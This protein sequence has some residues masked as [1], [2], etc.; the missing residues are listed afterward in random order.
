MR[1]MLNAQRYRAWRRIA[2]GHGDLFVRVRTRK[3]AR[4]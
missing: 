4:A 1:F 2:A 3:R